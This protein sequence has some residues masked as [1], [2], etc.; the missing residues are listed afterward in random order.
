MAKPLH[1]G[2]GQKHNINIELGDARNLRGI[3]N[4]T[5]NDVAGVMK[6]SSRR[7][8]SGD[9]SLSY[10]RKNLLFKNILSVVSNHSSDSPYGTFSDYVK[11]NPYWQAEDENGN[12]LRWAEAAH[13]TL[14]YQSNL[15]TLD[16]LHSLQ[17]RYA[18]YFIRFFLLMLIDDIFRFLFD[19][20]MNRCHEYN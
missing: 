2:V 17:F 13:N 1:T 6:S 7:N 19:E 10:R 3:L 8:F 14:S 11:M 15:P 5:Y 16:T 20:Y 12:I 9:V 4:F 18:N